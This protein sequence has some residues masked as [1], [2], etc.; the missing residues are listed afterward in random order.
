MSRTT[1]NN[2]KLI[3]LCPVCGCD[4]TEP[5]MQ[6]YMFFFKKPNGD[7]RCM[8]CNHSGN[9]FPEVHPSNLDVFREHLMESINKNL[10]TEVISL[11]KGEDEA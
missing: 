10:E 4:Q 2:I 7:Q 6:E 1:M 8:R 9:N 5:I 11:E 3:K